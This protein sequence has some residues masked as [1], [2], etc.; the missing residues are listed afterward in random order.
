MINPSR[1][2]QQ[3]PLETPRRSGGVTE[4]VLTSDAPEQ[5][6]L[7]LPMIAYLS[8]HCENRWVTWIA[9]QQI[10]R[11]LLESFGVNTRCIRLIHCK[12]PEQA[13]WV[14]WEALQAGNS[15]TVIASPGKLNEK[16]LL[17]L[18]LAAH[19]GSCQGLLLRLR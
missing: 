18:E 8:H 7:L 1:I 13:L 12:D 19:N 17:H 10:T 15:H 6:A 3:L 4:L 16:E 2:E 11:E 14:T 5:A 9:P